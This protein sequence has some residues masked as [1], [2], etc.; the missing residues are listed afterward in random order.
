M[1]SPAK[2]QIPESAVIKE[3]PKKK[4]RSHEKVKLSPSSTERRVSRK[5][6]KPVQWSWKRT[7]GLQNCGFTIMRSLNKRVANTW[8]C[9]LLSFLT[10]W[11]TCRILN[12]FY[13][14]FS[15]YLEAMCVVSAISL[16]VMKKPLF[17]NRKKV[18]Y[19]MFGI[20][21]LLV[22]AFMP[23]V[24]LM[25]SGLTTS[26]DSSGRMLAYL[27]GGVFIEV[28]LLCYY[29]FWARLLLALNTVA[30]KRLAKYKV[31]K[32]SSVVSLLF[33]RRHGQASNVEPFKR[34]PWNL[35]KELKSF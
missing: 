3:H 22:I 11:A 18:R 21:A 20:L 23:F 19:N 16:W 2:L 8:Y 27:V 24:T 6:Q 28:L 15:F 31:W 7:R 13:P 25:S 17:L 12:I 14:H 5:K 30:K 35:L 4:D 32:L 29:M 26:D 34:L 10:C 33:I 9:L 1:S